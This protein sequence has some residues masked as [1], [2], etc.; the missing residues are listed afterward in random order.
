MCVHVAC[1][2]QHPYQYYILLLRPSRS[3]SC[4]NSGP[5]LNIYPRTILST[6]GTS[7][8]DISHKRVLRAAPHKP[9]RSG[10]YLLTEVSY[11]FVRTKHSGIHVHARCTPRRRGR[12]AGTGAA[13]QIALEHARDR[14]RAR[15]RVFSCARS[16]G[17]IAEKS[18]EVLRAVG[19]GG[20][21]GGAHRAARGGCLNSMS[22]ASRYENK[23]PWPIIEA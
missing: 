22:I 1:V 16:R 17:P 4:M 7:G 12:A 5:R 3:G 21:G 19:G 11:C 6:P 8:Y 2:R 10:M 15:G 14:A 9:L 23:E 20:G 18:D 13:R